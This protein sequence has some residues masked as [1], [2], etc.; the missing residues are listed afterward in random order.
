MIQ[1]GRKNKR[2]VAGAAGERW[3]CQQDIRSRRSRA[4]LAEQFSQSIG[5][6]WPGDG[7]PYH[8]AV[9]AYG[10]VLGSTV[11]FPMFEEAARTHFQWYPNPALEKRL[12][13]PIGT[14][15]RK[16]SV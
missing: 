4:T 16:F 12:P 13:E 6:E 1:Q 14:D 10:S 11:R 2:R 7:V 15:C 5:G 3:A 9:R 8:P